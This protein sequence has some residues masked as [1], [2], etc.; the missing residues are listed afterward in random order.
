TQSHST[1]TNVSASVQQWIDLR[2]PIWTTIKD[3]RGPDHALGTA[4]DAPVSWWTTLYTGSQTAE[5]NYQTFVQAPY[6][7]IHATEGKPQPS[8]REYGVRIST[9]FRLSG[10]TEHHIWK[11]VN[12]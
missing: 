7:V 10:V 8:L 11:N 6:A 3:P 1:T 12:V 2:L 4:D 5:Q 9:N